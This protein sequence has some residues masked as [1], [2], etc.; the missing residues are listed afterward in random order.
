MSSIRE[1]IISNV[2]S[3]LE[4]VSTANGYNYDLSGRVSRT[5]KHWEECSE[6]PQV[7]VMDGA[8]SKVYGSNIMVDSTLEVV[9]RAYEHDQSDTSQKLNNLLEDIEKALCADHTRGGYAVNTIPL[10]IE[11]DEGWLQPF[12]ILEFRWS[13][14]YQYEY[15][16]P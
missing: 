3:T 9:I 10:K 6:F 14:F 4:A 8:E 2:I 12:G 5:L 7:F 13:I 1:N 16:T 11:T 15:G